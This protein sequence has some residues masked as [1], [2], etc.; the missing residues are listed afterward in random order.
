MQGTE[1]TREFYDRVGWTRDA[2]GH[3]VDTALFGIKAESDSPTRRELYALH[4]ARVLGAVGRIRLDMLEV[5]CGGNPERNL[6][7]VCRSY[8]GVD[9]SETGLP[10]AAKL[11]EGA[12]FPV[13]I[14]KADACSLPFKDASFDAAYSAHMIYHIEDPSAQAKALAEMMRVLRPGGRLVLIAANPR[15][16]LFWKPLL[17]RLVADSPLGPLVN[18]VR[19]PGVLPYAPQTIGWTLREL[20]RHGRASASVYAIPSTEFNQKVPEKGIGALA[21]KVVRWLDMRH[22]VV[23]ARLGCYVLYVAER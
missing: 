3:L 10:E 11:L 20:R 2:H 19:K 12:P 14:Q 15:P 4:V 21:W 7:P 22:P 1:A 8:T 5:G 16:L 17:R 23:S 6:L 18:R 9:F 13:A